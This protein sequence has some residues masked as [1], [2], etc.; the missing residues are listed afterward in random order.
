MKRSVL[1]SK[2]PRNVAGSEIKFK[3]SQENYIEFQL[4]RQFFTM[5][6]SQ[7]SFTRVTRVRSE[8]KWRMLMP[9]L[10]KRPNHAGARRADTTSHDLLQCP[11]ASASSPAVRTQ[12]S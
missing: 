10:C 11:V 3:L 12:Y 6:N 2:P 8:N 4:Q 7:N 5:I 1:T 9:V